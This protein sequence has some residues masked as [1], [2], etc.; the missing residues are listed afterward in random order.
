[1]TDGVFKL[2]ASVIFG[3][4]WQASGNLAALPFIF[5]AGMAA[6]AAVLLGVF[7]QECKP[8]LSSSGGE[9]GG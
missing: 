7:C 5:G 2:F 6:A 4:M 3:V 1:M 9:T 8:D